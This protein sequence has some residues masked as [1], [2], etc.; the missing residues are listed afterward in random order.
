MH[1]CRPLKKQVVGRLA[2]SGFDYTLALLLD[3]SFESLCLPSTYPSQDIVSSHLSL[4]TLPCTLVPL[5]LPE[6]YSTQIA[7]GL[8]VWKKI[9]TEALCRL[10]TRFRPR[11]HA[12]RVRVHLPLCLLPDG[13]SNSDTGLLATFRVGVRRLS[14]QLDHRAVFLITLFRASLSPCRAGLAT[15]KRFGLE[16][17]HLPFCEGA[18]FTYKQIVAQ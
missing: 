16:R 12:Y 2:C 15:P 18:S 1:A 9:H 6:T 13:G 10:L 5:R 3:N 14:F 8:P 4:E 7:L 11:K 17:S